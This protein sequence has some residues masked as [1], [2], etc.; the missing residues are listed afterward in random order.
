[1][2]VYYTASSQFHKESEDTYNSTIKIL[3]GKGLTVIPMLSRTFEE[4]DSGNYVKSSQE[5]E[6]GLKTADVVI[7]DITASS[8]A[9]GYF[10]ASALNQKKPVLVLRMKKAKKMRT[11][12]PIIGNK[13]KLMQF[14]EYETQ[15]ELESIINDFINFA[16]KKLDT[17]FILIISPEIDRYLEWASDH[18]RMHKAQLVRNAIEKLMDE[19][20]EWKEFLTT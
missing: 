4:F 19:D 12:G 5:Q 1:M 20:E 17:K 10:V 2:K 16:T 8:G 6:K 14:K 18:K 9:V 13:S 11:P 15:E 7:A 3:E